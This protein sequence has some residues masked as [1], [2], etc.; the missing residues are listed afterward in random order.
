MP[1]KGYIGLFLQIVLQI[2]EGK[3]KY[4]KLT[5]FINPKKRQKRT[6]SLKSEYI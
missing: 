3:L 2:R 5:N 1:T 6:F 4:S